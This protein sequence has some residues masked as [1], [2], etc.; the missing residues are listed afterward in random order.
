MEQLITISEII[1]K[2]GTKGP[3]KIVTSSNGA[4]F[5]C[6]LPSLYNLLKTGEAVMADVEKS[7]NYN[8]IKAIN[9]SAPKPAAA[10]PPQPAPQP[11]QSNSSRPI[12][13]GDTNDSI[14]GQVAFKGA[15]ELIVAGKSETNGRLGL[16]AQAYAITRLENAIPE[17]AVM[18]V[19]DKLAEIKPK[20]AEAK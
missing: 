19:N 16:L 6:F 5:Y 3:F 7:G 9:M 11:V 8:H 1:E 20:K 13:M 17:A 10:S 15:V 2:S 12:R 14:E 18:A 4:K